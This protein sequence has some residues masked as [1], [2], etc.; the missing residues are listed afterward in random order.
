MMT[1]VQEHL[2]EFDIWEDVKKAIIA[3]VR[4]KAL[5]VEFAP[6][7][8]RRYSAS[9]AIS[10]GAMIQGSLTRKKRT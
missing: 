1:K 4:A 2:D 3:L 6:D 7:K 9:I 10:K 8:G 5:A